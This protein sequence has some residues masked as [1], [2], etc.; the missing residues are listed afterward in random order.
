MPAPYYVGDEIPLSFEAKDSSGAGPTAV[1]VD[2]YDPTNTKI[3]DALAATT[4]GTTVTYNISETL[5]DT[6]GVIRSVFKITFTGTI[7][8]RHTIHTVVVDPTVR[9]F[10]YGSKELVEAMVGDIVVGRVFTDSTTPTAA[11]VQ[12]LLDGVAAEMNVEMRQQGYRIPLRYGDDPQAYLNAV[13]ANNAGTAARVLSTMPMEA[14]SLPNEGESG[15]DRREMWDRELWHF[16]QRVRRGDLGAIKD[17]SLMSTMFSG[18]QETSGGSKKLPL[19]TRAGFD[20]PGSRRLT[21]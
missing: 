12:A 20:F 21:E 18:S 2:V 6:V 13:H 5:N 10:T 1:L 4:N 11:T 3:V 16:L 9:Y 19:F 8:R 15:G 17:S 14:Y 7:V